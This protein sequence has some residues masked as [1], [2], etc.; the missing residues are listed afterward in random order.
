MRDQQTLLHLGLGRVGRTL[1]SQL[2]ALPLFDSHGEKGAPLLYGGYFTSSGGWMVLDGLS[3]L[4]L[5]QVAATGRVERLAGERRVSAAELLAFLNSAPPQL[6]KRT[7]L[8]DT[9][10]A[11]ELIPLL[12]VALSRGA[13][14]VTANKHVLTGPQRDFDE[15]RQAGGRRFF[16]ETTVGAGLPVIGTL[17][18][19]LASGDTVLSISGCMSGTLGYI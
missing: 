12:R 9:S 2:A 19:L 8:V 17:A 13:R 1:V 14:V 6:L 18:S 16:Y 5:A 15:L 4:E 10:H 3:A 11:T 7:I